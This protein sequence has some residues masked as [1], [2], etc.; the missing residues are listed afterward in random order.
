[1]S[2]QSFRFL[3]AGGFHLHAVLQ[4]VAE[5]PEHLLEALISAPYRAAEQVFQTAIREEVDFVVLTGDLLD[6][7]SGGPRAVAFLVKQ[8]ELLRDHGI[9]VYWTAS[10]LDLSTDWLQH[11]D[12]PSNVHVFSDDL[13]E[14][15]TIVVNECAAAVVV[16]R[17]WNAQRPLRTAEF[18]YSAGA[19][20]QLA[21]L[22]GACETDNLPAGMEFWAM[23]GASEPSTNVVAKQVVHSPGWSQGFLPGHTGAHGCTLVHVDQAGDIRTRRIETDVLRW[24][25]ER[26][27][28][29]SGVSIQDVRSAMRT[30]IQKL[31]AD[32]SRI[33]LVDWILVGDGWFDSV[34]VHQNR[35]DE[36]LEWLRNEF[37]KGAEA[38]WSLSLEI[39][40]PEKL[41][42]EWTDED[43][44]LG[45]FLRV[46]GEYID[47][48]N[49]PLVLETGN[50]AEQLPAELVAALPLSSSALRASV[51]RNAALL[52]VNLLRGDERATETMALLGRDD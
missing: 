13:V 45:D 4:G 39:E 44:I 23:G 47:D 28:T 14:Q 46:T 10:K 25:H 9:P 50:A 15:K 21:V 18:T 6:A 30:R 8:F 12:L 34:L 29:P 52:G 27:G 19:G 35:R 32:A 40:P 5:A 51:L 7:A 37:G 17:S 24:V 33:V 16:G 38:V 49:K 11:V 43:S 41:R 42:D 3:C 22:Y 48:E 20:I 36:L 1:M 2:A 31:M 26:L